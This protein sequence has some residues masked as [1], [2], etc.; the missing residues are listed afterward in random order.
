[1]LIFTRK[2]KESFW[3]NDEVCVTILESKGGRT[4]IGINA[5]EEVNVERQE[6]RN[7]R[8]AEKK[9]MENAA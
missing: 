5:P 1:M 3:I 8:I 2:N 9:D 6:V 7:A 4:R